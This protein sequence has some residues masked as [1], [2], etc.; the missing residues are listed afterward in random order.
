MLAYFVAQVGVGVLGL[1]DGPSGSVAAFMPTN[2]LTSAFSALLVLFGILGAIGVMVRPKVMFW[3]LVGLAIA[4][5]LHGAAI[6]IE[7]SYRGDPIQTGVRLLG[8]PLMMIGAGWCAYR[9]A[10]LSW[11]LAKDR[12]R[13]DA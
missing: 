8:A 9:Q 2:A 10:M 4:T 12:P 1:T 7:A 11:L 3:A 6:V 13:D 5:A